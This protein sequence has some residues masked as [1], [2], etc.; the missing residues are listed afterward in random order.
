MSSLGSD[1]LTDSGNGTEALSKK[2]VC[3]AVSF[4]FMS[5]FQQG[6]AHKQQT[7]CSTWT[8]NNASLNKTA[9]EDGASVL[10]CVWFS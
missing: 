6:R 8:T 3:L 7:E 4:Q 10:G 5:D 1:I 9:A 2:N